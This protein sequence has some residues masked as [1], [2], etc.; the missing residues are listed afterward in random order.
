MTKIQIITEPGAFQP[1]YTRPT[2]AGM[3]VRA[4]ITEPIV[5]KPLERKL[6][7]TGNKVNL[8]LGIELQVRPRSGLALKHGI[9]VLNSPGTV[10]PGYQGDIGVILINLGNED[11]EIKPAERIAQLVFSRY[12]E[13][14][15]EQVEAFEASERG[16]KGFGS[17]GR[18]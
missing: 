8:P 14:E 15:L 1:A 5:L 4:F 13:A 3:D 16:S 17:S 7:P 10:D 9:T 12:E 6:I 11:F 2:D 18:S